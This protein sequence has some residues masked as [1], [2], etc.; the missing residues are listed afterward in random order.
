MGE[1]LSLH[2]GTKVTDGI[3]RSMYL[4]FQS[5][6]LHWSQFLRFHMQLS[7]D[8]DRL[9]EK[10]ISYGH[11]SWPFR[12]ILVPMRVPSTFMGSPGRRV[13]GLI[14]LGHCSKECAWRGTTG[15]L[16]L[17]WRRVSLSQIDE[18][19]HSF[20]HQVLPYVKLPGFLSSGW[21]GAT[22]TAL[23]RNNVTHPDCTGSAD[24]CY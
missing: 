10:H 12:S 19:H 8:L 21:E 13:L 15:Q 4:A 9:R 2:F 24:V 1:H 20:L 6:G 7:P 22:D 14:C 3:G 16:R 11:F 23:H 5:A 18:E 17:T